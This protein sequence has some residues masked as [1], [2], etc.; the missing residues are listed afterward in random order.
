[1]T[2]DPYAPIVADRAPLN[3]VKWAARDYASIFDDL[4]RRLKAI[5]TTVYNDYA[6]TVQGIM[7]LEL[8]AYATAQ[9]QWYLDRTASDCFLETARTLPAA[10]RIVKQSGYKI[11]PAA[12]SST[13]LDVTFPDGT[14]AGFTMPA[15]WRYQGPDSLVFESYAA[16]VE[17]GPVA[18]GT[19]IPVAVRQGETRILTFTA[20]GTS[21]QPY[22]LSGIPTGKYVADQSVEVWVDGLEWTERSFLTYVADEQFEVDYAD[23]PPTVRFGDGIAGLIP[24]LGAEVKVRFVVID[25]AKGNNP[26]AN[27]I[28]TSLDTLLVGGVAVTLEVTNLDAPTGGADPEETDRARKLAPL[29]FAARGAAI[30]EPDYEALS[31]SFVDPLYGAVAKAYAFNPRG[32]YNDLAFN[33]LVEAVEDLLVDYVLVVQTLEDNIVAAGA[34]M[35]PLLTVITDANA[36]LEVLRA[37]MEGYVGAA[38]AAVQAARGQCTTAETAITTLNTAGADQKMTLDDLHQYVTLGGVDPAVI[39]AY[40]NT[41]LEY[42]TTVTTK[43]AAALSA[44]QT[45]GTALDT[46]VADQLN[47]TLD[48]LTNVA[49]V[50]PASSLPKVE[51]DITGAA[52]ALDASIT[53]LETKTASID[54][55][56]AALEVN[57]NAQTAAMRARIATLFSD[58]CMS[59]YVQVPILS[60]DADGA[61]VAPSVGLIMGLQAYLDG[62]KEVTQQVD[63]IDGTPA[64]SQATIEVELMVGTVYVYAEE[65]A[66]VQAAVFQLLKGRDF[67]QPLYLSDLYRVVEAASVGIDYVNIHITGPVAELDSDGNLVPAPNKIIKLAVSG[68]TI[69]N[70]AA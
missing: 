51:A 68:L 18:A 8:M 35:D 20:D 9:L 10:N 60:L 7:L 62:I 4:L 14:T 40:V 22:L 38:K 32:T 30:T 46:V 16:V 70:L 63:V 47:P 49:P 5:Y 57:I 3:A 25:G 53:A 31:N 42:N 6:T 39:L 69:T 37:A 11:R 15:R 23:D 48:R 29:S 65:A 2:T 17:P 58:D 67:N 12:A 44:V 24:P 64:L 28:T 45:A 61:Y 43:G 21:N 59:N 19:V 52:A 41:A 66:K 54:G 55:R 26:K 36:A 33:D 1:M 50:A 34:V 13:S 27:S 56:A